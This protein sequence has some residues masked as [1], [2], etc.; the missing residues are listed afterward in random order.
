MSE[1]PAM[2]ALTAA[3]TGLDL[4]ALLPHRAPILMLDRLL[5]LDP[6][7][8]ARA[9]KDVRADDRC[10]EGHFPG[11]PVMPGV[12]VIEAL[13]QTACALAMASLE[14][15]QQG[16]WP[17]LLSIDQARFR[18]AVRPGDRL[19]L[20]VRCTRAWGPFWR[21]E[22]TASVDGLTAAQA[23]LLATM[24]AALPL[25]AAANAPHP[26]PSMNRIGCAAGLPMVNEKT[27]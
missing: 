8:E 2:A 4:A 23:R 25:L 1:A 11:Y 26:A 12:L 16:R 9:L 14:A 5:S 27:A 19:E 6:G 7:R 21:F 17:V 20:H 24:T 18:R 13:A 15:P 3:E 22:A 10:L